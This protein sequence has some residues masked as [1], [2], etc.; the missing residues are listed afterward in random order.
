L[1][2]IR[3]DCHTSVWEINWAELGLWPLV[4]TVPT[5]T[6]RNGEKR[7]KNYMLEPE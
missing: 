4:W 1:I 3:V 7:R 2:V 6:A 5:I